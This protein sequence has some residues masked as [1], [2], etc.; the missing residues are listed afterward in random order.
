MSLF[1]I[2]GIM[3]GSNLSD[4]CRSFLRENGDTDIRKLAHEVFSTPIDAIDEAEKHAETGFALYRGHVELLT[5]HTSTQIW[6][7]FAD[8]TALLSDP[9]RLSPRYQ[10]EQLCGVEETAAGNEYRIALADP[11]Y[12]VRLRETCAELAGLATGLDV[13]RMDFRIERAGP[14]GGETA[15]LV[16]APLRNHA[17]AGLASLWAVAHPAQ[18]GKTMRV[19]LDCCEVTRPA[20]LPD[21]AAGFPSTL[22]EWRGL[23]NRLTAR[24]E[25]TA[26]EN[27]QYEE[28]FSHFHDAG[29]INAEMAEAFSLHPAIASM[30]KQQPENAP[31]DI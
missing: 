23:L 9:D 3:S 10:I 31:H 19:T 21:L 13:R 28:S 25:G 15:E 8:L 18:D 4:H 14:W 16:L 11:P 22:F 24:I 29:A 1:G 26:A 7:A 17:R 12:R 2:V 30:L 20:W 5:R 27:A 6:S